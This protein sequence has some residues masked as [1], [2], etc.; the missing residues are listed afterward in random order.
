M[1]S[2]ELKPFCLPFLG[3]TTSPALGTLAQSRAL[4]GM[5]GGGP[6]YE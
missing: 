1:Q 4:P 6:G 3:G 2:G 5:F